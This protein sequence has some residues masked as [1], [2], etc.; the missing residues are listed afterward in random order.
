MSERQPGGAERQA[1]A[2]RRR[3]LRAL[4]DQLRRY[5]VNHEFGH[6]LGNMSA[7]SLAQARRCQMGRRA[8]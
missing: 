2:P 1:L 4:T 7:G 3:S 6:A 5:Q 8:A